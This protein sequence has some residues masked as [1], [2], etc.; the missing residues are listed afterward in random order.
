[1]LKAYNVSKSAVKSSSNDDEET[2]MPKKAR[3]APV[4]RKALPKASKVAKK[5]KTED[6]SEE[7]VK[8]PM[9]SKPPTASKTKP[10]PKAKGKVKK[11]EDGDSALSG[12]Q[13]L[14]Y[15]R[16]VVT[17]ADI[18]FQILLRKTTCLT[19]TLRSKLNYSHQ[20]AL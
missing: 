9:L 1:M 6:D 14:L 16:S 7:D 19:P 13:R 2:P 12:K 15:Y 3:A 17:Y 5:A 10:K 18:V 11:E 8:D 4:K 20:V